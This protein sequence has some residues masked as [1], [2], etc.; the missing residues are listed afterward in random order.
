MLSDDARHGRAGTVVLALL[1]GILLLSLP[2]SRQPCWDM[3]ADGAR[4]VQ[5]ARSLARGEGYTFNGEPY[6]LRPPGFSAMLLPVIWSHGLDFQ[7]LSLTMSLLGALST[8]ALFLLVRSWIGDF[9]AL[10]LSLL[11]WTNPKV[12]W[13]CNSVQSDVPATGL[14]LLAL[15][16]IGRAERRPS[17]P[18]DLAAAV[19]ILAAVYVRINNAVLLPAWA[20]GR[21]LGGGRET[22]DAGGWARRMLLPA[23]VVLVG[24]MPWAAWV[25]QAGG[26]GP[27]TWQPVP[28]YA[29]AY[30]R[31]DPYDPESP[32]LRAT[33][34]T[35]RLGRNAS[36]YAALFASG[37]HPASP[38]PLAS[39]LS[40]LAIACCVVSL[41]A[42]HSTAGWFTLGSIATLLPF[43]W[44]MD[45]YFVLPFVLLW[46]S[47]AAVIRAWALASRTMGSRRRLLDILLT[48][49]LLTL[50]AAW[51]ERDFL[52]PGTCD[53]YQSLLQLG[54]YVREEIP[55]QTMVAGDT[56]AVYAAVADRVVYQVRGVEGEWRQRPSVVLLSRGG[57]CTEL[58]AEA[59]R[60]G[61]PHREFGPFVLIQFPGGPAGAVPDAGC[62][63]VPGPRRRRAPVNAEVPP[64]R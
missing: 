43:A 38:R 25:S 24:W 32:A 49:G 33:E 36:V 52:P 6:T 55:A 4:Y 21:A 58:A 16:L 31:S 11:F 53:S 45:R 37:L 62:R 9:P 42:P 40:A 18:R 63:K 14:A 59:I 1:V 20:L 13:L 27:R 23:A 48:A 50:A 8:V 10:G 28:S 64:P 46:G 26:E 5:L 30:L 57:P 51:F 41:R 39:L 12:Q 47:V 7:A 19:A 54:R 17:L 61:R 3:A 35:S 2:W 34:L 29:T 60:A 44:I 56:A 22:K 15:L